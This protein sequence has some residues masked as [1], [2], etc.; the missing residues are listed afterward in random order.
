M[1]TCH[2]RNKIISFP[3]IIDRDQIFLVVRH[4]FIIIFTTSWQIWAWYTDVFERLKEKRF[5]A[6][7]LHVSRKIRS[8]MRRCLVVCIL[9]IGMIIGD[10]LSEN[11]KSTLMVGDWQ[12]AMCRLLKLF[13]T[14]KVINLSSKFRWKPFLQYNYQLST[15]KCQQKARSSL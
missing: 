7:Y 9:V 12:C 6:D 14:K 11:L 4:A 1:S 15:A 13:L 3:L 10:V 2:V 8:N 5:S